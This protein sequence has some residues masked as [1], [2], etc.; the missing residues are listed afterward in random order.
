MWRFEMRGV[1]NGQWLAVFFALVVLALGNESAFAACGAIPSSW[2]VLA[3]SRLKIGSTVKVNG[4]PVSNSD[5]SG[6][7]GVNPTTGAV[8]NVS[9]AMPSLDPASFPGFSGGTSP[10]SP[11]SVAAGTYNTITVTNGA[12]TPDTTFTGGTYYIGSLS[13]AANASVQLA[14]GDYFIRTLSIGDGATMTVSPAGP[15]RLYLNSNPAIGSNVVLNSGGSA[16]N[17]QI[18]LYP[19]V[20]EF[21]PGSSTQF[22]GVVYAPGGSQKIRF[23]ASSV[24]TGALVTAGELELEDNIVLNYGAATQAQVATVSTCPGSGSLH[25]LEISSSTS[26]TGLTCAASTLTI[27]AC[28][29]AAVP[30]V[31][32]YTGGVSGTLS[33]TGSG[34]TVSWDGTTGGATGSGFVI[35]ASGS[36]T[37]NVQV[38]TAGTVTLG[39]ATAT[40]TPTNATTC[41]FGTNAPSN[42]NCVFT[43][44]T[45]GFIF[46]NT[47]TGNTYTI[48]PQVSG[49]ATAAN[50]LYLRAV[51]A[52]TTNPAVCTPAIISS[53]TA[54]NIGYACNNPA[55]CQTGNLATINATAI[56]P[57]G[58][59]V[60]LAFDANGSVPI[61]ARY[62]DVGR[63]TLSANASVTPVFT[64][65]TPVVLNGSS[66]A[67]VVAPHHFGISGV[68][69]AP[70]KAG[71]NFSTTVTAY[72]GL[73]T[74]T[75][76]KN[77]G[78]ETTPEGV[79]MSF[80]KCQP[81]G[82]GSANGAFSAS[83]PAFAGGTAT[84][85]NFNWS[86]VGN[87]DLVA[88]LASGNYLGS[89][90]TAMGNTGTGGTVCS[91]GAGNVGRF[92][93]DHF[94]TAFIDGCVGCGFTYSG[95][96]FTVSVTAKNGLAT[97]TTTVNYDGTSSTAPNFAKA[98]TL[99]AWDAVTGLIQNPGGSLLPPASTA[100]A[101]TAFS[102]GVASLNTAA[103]MP[104]YTFTTVPTVPTRIRLRAV[105]T[106]N[107]TSLRVPLSS[108]TEGQPEIRTGRIKVFNVYGSEL[109]QL[110]I[111][112]TAQYW[113]DA[114]AGWVTISTDSSSSFV[115]ATPPAT[116][117][118]NFA[119]YQ[120]N[121]TAVSIA[122]SPKTVLLSSGVGGFTL[123]APGFGNS[124]SVDMSIPGLAGASC[125]V[126]PTPLGCYLPSNTARATFGIYKS[127][128]IY[129][130]ENY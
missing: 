13:V 9:A 112:V 48:P 12:A 68:T 59:S 110:P 105:D 99:S 71:N 70:I 49:I 24:I 93:P 129:R 126:A 87:G 21:R 69:A 89:G 84:A 108:S 124:G 121:L 104:F 2:P 16:A 85:A 4:L 45:A 7:Y 3:G 122:G 101:L 77:F 27:K 60:N 10:S 120:K 75:A 19:G 76:T 130:R 125:Y 79:T 17:L 35:P 61:T 91:T 33:A 127:P 118:V 72:N 22:T 43:A 81:T 114:T 26:G 56:A 40:P 78:L 123:S 51:Q 111:A 96:R 23:E 95:Q 113:K 58:T 92:I 53:T 103:T 34:M 86:E 128:L 57:G 31:S 100:V 55:T 47:T 29:D 41:N 42:D 63:I 65:A 32:L 6:I 109:L 54:V 38:A 94:D 90:L 18:Y 46:S 80:A 102:Q 8:Q 20:S 36:V 116:S 117:A 82:V 106:D 44:N 50:A 14:P 107:V 1:I 28:T 62:D 52:S 88:T 83:L 25:H 37:K 39:V 15:V 115:V 11:S 73:V 5:S 74:S 64:G 98:V 67:F 97:P 30:C 66:N 119:N